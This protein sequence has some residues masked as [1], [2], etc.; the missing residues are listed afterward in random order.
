MQKTISRTNVTYLFFA[1]VAAGIGGC[2]SDASDTPVD[3]NNDTSG[4]CDWDQENDLPEGADELTLDTPEE[5][6][7]CPLTDQDWYRL[8]LPSSADLIRVRLEQSGPA[9]AVNPVYTVFAEDGT[10]V[11]AAPNASES[12][13]LDSPLEIVHAVSSGSCY[14]RV[15]DQAQDKSD[16][17][18]PYTLTVSALS[19]PDTQE[20]N[21][22]ASAAAEIND[23]AAV[24]GYVA[25]RGDEDWYKIEA[26][27]RDILHVSIT[28]DGG[29]APSYR[30]MDATEADV[31]TRANEAGVSSYDYYD[32]LADGGTYYIVVYNENPLSFDTETPYSMEIAV[33]PDPDTHEGNNTPEESTPLNDSPTAC[34]T[35]WSDWSSAEGYIASSGDIDWYQYDVSGSET[36]ILEVEVS[37]GA[38]SLPENLHPAVRLVYAAEKSCTRHQDCQSLTTTCTTDFDCSRLG[39]TCLTSGLCGGSGNCMP[40]GTCGA[41]LIYRTSAPDETSNPDASTGSTGDP[42]TVRV[43]APLFGVTTMY[44]AVEDYKGDALS[45]TAAYTV[46]A[47]VATDTDTHEPSEAYL[48]RPPQQDDDV[49]AHEASTSTN[50][51]PVHTCT[52]SDADDCCDAGTWIE[53]AISYTYD[54]D[55]YRYEHPCP[56]EDCMVRINFETEAGPVD[57]YMMVYRG[58]SLWHDEV[59]P[60]LS[61]TG[62]QVAISGACGGLEAD[63]TCFYAYH[64]HDAYYFSVR[65]TNYVSEGNENNGTWDWNKDQR[66]RFC[67]EKIADEC[68]APCHVYDETGCGPMYETDTDTE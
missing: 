24:T 22:E 60:A 41:T 61:D 4:P 18:H 68:L 53:G 51:V 27:A 38:A 37:F 36:G 3:T 56:E 44:I 15:L 10:T 32:S 54:Q 19:D 58:G 26:S 13:M 33:T 28:L 52:G 9:P 62:D 50:V 59:L 31:V 25:Y 64:L 57:T 66:Y 1:C 39:N 8:S 17:Y 14:I 11:L 67:I 30:V 63:D 65:D 55:W 46:R 29:I 35:E 12:A 16:N 20:P 21:N 49:S 48:N 47:R 40:D 6:F 45:A 23:G 42:K 43:A 34:G 2:K 7:I 5:R